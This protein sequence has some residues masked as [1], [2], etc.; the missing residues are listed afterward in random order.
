MELDAVE[1]FRRF[2][3]ALWADRH[4]AVPASVVSFDANG[5][6][7]EA[8]ISVKRR[9]RDGTHETFPIISNVPVIYPGTAEFVLE[10]PLVKGD[11]V[12]LVFSGYDLRKWAAATSTSPVNA[13]SGNR[14]QLSDAFAIPGLFPARASRKRGQGGVQLLYKNAKIQITAAEQLELDTPQA[15][16][17]LNGGAGVEIGPAASLEKTV[18][19]ET[20]KDELDKSQA[21]LEKLQQALNSWSP[22]PGDGGTALKTALVNFLA[23]ALPDYGEILS[24]KVKIG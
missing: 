8:K 21:A 24:D 6:T 11:G 14:F 5:P 3:D 12:L 19:G 15:T 13:D 17:K 16:L 10:Y 20:L 2:H 22:T 4:T 7:I 9:L 1:E 23:A 18:L